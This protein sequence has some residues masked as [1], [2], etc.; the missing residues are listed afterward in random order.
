MGARNKALAIQVMV[1]ELGLQ[2]SVSVGLCPSGHVHFVAPMHF[3]DFLDRVTAWASGFRSERLD[4]RTKRVMWALD[5]IANLKEPIY[6]SQP[7]VH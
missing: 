4:E 2:E 3:H 7:N 5:N 6:Q 1:E